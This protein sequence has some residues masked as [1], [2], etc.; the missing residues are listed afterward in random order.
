LAFS[1]DSLTLATAHWLRPVY[2]WDV[3]T[4]DKKQ[5]LYVPHHGALSLA[6]SPEG[7]TLAASACEE[8]SVYL[9]PFTSQKK[10]ILLKGHTDCICTMAYSS[11]G[12]RL[13]TG[14]YDG[15]VRLWDPADGTLLATYLALP[16]G[17]WVVYTPRGEYKASEGATPYFYWRQGAQLLAA[18][19][20]ESRPPEPERLWPDVP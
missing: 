3:Q 20:F 6:F 17:E 2:L 16:T 8:P 9:M 19:A 5:E 13:A 7:K 18:E 14:G 11:D 10:E 1:P 4:G 12:T 15:T